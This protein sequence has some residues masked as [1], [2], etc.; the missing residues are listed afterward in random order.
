MNKNKY[1][2]KNNHCKCGK[3]ITNKAKQCKKCYD[4][5]R[6]DTLI[7]HKPNCQCVGCKSK[8]GEHAGINA[9]FYGKH[10][11]KETK[12]LMKQNKKGKYLGK[13]NPNYKHGET[14][15]KH[16]CIICK[17]NEIDYGN[18]FYG[19]KMCKHCVRKGELGSMYGKHHTLK[20]RKLI[21]IKNKGKLKGRNNPHFGK[22]THGKGSYYK[23]IWMRSTW[24]VKY[25][26]YLDKNKIKW[27]YE[28][29]TF[30]LGN[31]TYTPDFYLPKT[32]EYIEIKG[33]WRKNS[34]RRFK[35]F[36]KLYPKIKIK[37]LMNRDLQ[38]LGVL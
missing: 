34:L 26:K 13:K 33:W 31:C 35:L 30:D 8:R 28:Y 12:K 4:L 16:Y 29:K 11:T 5:N 1:Y 6:K 10:H 24:E 14:L 37:V 27:H 36:K 21:S 15:K 23:E 3:L 20:A 25:A 7:N 22:I 19:S 17:V 38:I 9:P 32:N 18:W 2:T